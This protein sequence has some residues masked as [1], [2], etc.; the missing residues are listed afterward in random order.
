MVLYEIFYSLR[1]CCRVF[2]HRH[3]T[4]QDKYFTDPEDHVYDWRGVL[5]R[6][7]YLTT[8]LQNLESALKKSKAKWKLVIG[9]HTIKS[10][11]EHGNTQELVDKVLPIL[12]ANG[13]DL[14]INGHD[15]CLQQIASSKSGLQFMTSGVGSKA[16]RGVYNW[17]NPNEMK[18]FYDGQ[19]FMTMHITHQHIVVKFY[20]ISGNILHKW[21]TSPRP[22]IVSNL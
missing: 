22:S 13:V 8:L 7:K 17:T 11:S 6:E 2:L 20:D 4:V 9:H 21:S 18:F 12:E 5:P 3:D 19:G 10:A 1:R 15:H 14:Y 16:W